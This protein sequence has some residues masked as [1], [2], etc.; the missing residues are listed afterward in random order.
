MLHLTSDISLLHCNSYMLSTTIFFCIMQQNGWYWN[1][2]YFLRFAI[3]T[4]SNFFFC[5]YE[6]TQSVSGWNWPH[7]PDKINKKKLEKVS[8]LWY[9]GCFT[10]LT[11]TGLAQDYNRPGR[12]HEIPEILNFVLK[13]PDFWVKSC[14][15]YIYPEIFTR[16]HNFFYK[17][18]SFY[19]WVSNTGHRESSV[20]PDFSIKM[21]CRGHSRSIIL[22]SLESG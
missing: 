4:W 11:E 21:A 1:V 8:V 12:C 5:A 18:T 7:F 19:L 10:Q 2:L 6:V 3:G 14:N 16:F 20:V 22:R 17:H 15:L 9:P 13:C